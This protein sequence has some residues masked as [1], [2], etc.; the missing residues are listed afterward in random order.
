MVVYRPLKNSYD[1]VMDPTTISL[2]NLMT[3]NDARATCDGRTRLILRMIGWS[4]VTA[5]G[6]AVMPGDWMIQTAK[7][8]GLE[9]A[10]V[11]LSFYLARNLSLMYAMAGILMIL[12]ALTN[13]LDRRLIRSLGITGIILGIFQAIVG[14]QSEMPAWWIGLESVTTAIGGVFLWWIGSEP[15]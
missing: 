2:R 14:V 4:T 1:G 3:N 11:P 6:A 13:P 9:L 7:W 5:F 8:F 12:V 15:S 10:D